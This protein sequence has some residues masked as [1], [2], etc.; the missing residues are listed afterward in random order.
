MVSALAAVILVG[1]ML[2]PIV[3]IAVGLIAGFMLGGPLGAVAGLVI[4]LIICAA[5]SGAMQ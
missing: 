3:N 2:F 4:A 1:L 5:W